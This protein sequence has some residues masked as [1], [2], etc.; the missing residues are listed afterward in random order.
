MGPP[1]HFLS[2]AFLSVLPDLLFFPAINVVSSAYLKLF[3]VLPAIFTPSFASSISAFRLICIQDFI[4]LI[5]AKK[6]LPIQRKKLCTTLGIWGGLNPS[7]LVIWGLSLSRP[8][9]EPPL[10]TI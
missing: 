7:F 5:I 2:L 9:T 10:I 8:Y 1:F 6:V 3:S 4:C